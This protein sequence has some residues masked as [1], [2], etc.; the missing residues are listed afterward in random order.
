ME[1]VVA[2]LVDISKVQGFGCIGVE[3]VLRILLMISGKESV[4]A[5]YWG[6]GDIP[7]SAKRC[8]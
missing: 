3:G 2:A 1:L 6:V 5:W 7:G 8:G 4:V